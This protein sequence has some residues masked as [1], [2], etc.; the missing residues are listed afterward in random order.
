[1]F[2]L[3]HCLILAFILFM[4]G[5]FG[6]FMRRSFL[7]ILIS[8]EIIFNAININFVAFNHFLYPDNTLGQG[9]VLFVITLSVAEIV[10]GLSLSVLISKFHHTLEID[11]LFQIQ[12]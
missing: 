6:L 8:L 1:M 7:S 5:I 3:N 10:I 12:G 9:W 2:T 4:I 11:E